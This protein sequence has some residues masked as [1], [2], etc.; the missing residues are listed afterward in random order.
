MNRMTLLTAPFRPALTPV[1]ILAFVLLG[2]SHSLLAQPMSKGTTHAPLVSKDTF[3][4]IQKE[5]SGAITLKQ[6]MVLEGEHRAPGR[7]DILHSAAAYIAEQAKK[8]GL[9]EVTTLKQKG[10][11]PTW[12]ITSADLWIT[13]PERF[14][15]TSFDETPWSIAPFSGGGLQEASVVDVGKGVVDGDY[16]QANVSGNIVLASG[17]P[18]IVVQQAVWRRGALGAICYQADGE[19]DGIPFGILPLPTD[20]NIGQGAFAYM[21]SSRK[22]DEIK[23]MLGGG[24]A[25]ADGKRASNTVRVTARSRV[26]SR[27]TEPGEQILI[28]ALIYGE[29]QSLPEVLVTARLEDFPTNTSSGSTGCAGLLEMS[30][31]LK[32]LIEQGNLARP[33]RTIRFWW[34]T[35]ISGI[36]EHFSQH[37]D[38]RRK[39][40]GAVHVDSLGESAPGARSEST[41][42][43]VG[44]SLFRPSFLADFSKLT[45]DQVSTHIKR[46]SQGKRMRSF[47]ATSFFNPRNT[48]SYR[49]P[50]VHDA[51]SEIPLAIT[52]VSLANVSGSHVRPIGGNLSSIHPSALKEDILAATILVYSLA[53]V[54]DD[55]LIPI[56]TG[57]LRLSR[58]RLSS[59]LQH[60]THLIDDHPTTNDWIDAQSTFM[61]GLLHERTGLGSITSLASDPKVSAFITARRDSLWSEGGIL[62]KDLS[63]TFNYYSGLEKPGSVKT[64]REESAVSSKVP[65]FTG[66][67]GEHFR[68]RQPAGALSPNLALSLTT[69]RP[70]STAVLACVDSRS[71]YPEI[72]RSVRAANHLGGGNVYGEVVTLTKV[73]EILDRAVESGAIRANTVRRR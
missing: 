18:R 44:P 40:L 64:T 26:D 16:R 20:K 36:Y 42:T 49:P 33:Q 5:L 6:T 34:V 32:H 50:L 2:A 28:E 52:A 9:R 35:G 4:V 73:I 62:M 66:A 37:P 14:R 11:F 8:H 1:M 57:L 24:V 43:V 59:E 23:K 51:L 17:P 71:T 54:Q 67:L 53:N 13:G 55:Q 29:N 19:P 60:V 21:I 15:L 47:P 22:A 68:L 27:N 61:S 25:P 38:Q 10:Y 65:E 30:R 46:T 58:E 63:E 3:D 45:L 72:Y 31:A 39:F 56:T 69:Y 70:L 12:N 48:A 41:T 7:Y